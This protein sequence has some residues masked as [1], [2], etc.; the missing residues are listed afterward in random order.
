MAKSK[1]KASSKKS[2]LKKKASS[3]KSVLKKKVSLKKSATKKAIGKKSDDQEYKALYQKI[4]RRKKL[5]QEISKSKKKGWKA[6]RSKVYKEI[7]GLNKEIMA[8]CK[9]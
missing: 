6:K 7:V 9:R 2:V 8:L 5:K 3:K 4:Y 1:K